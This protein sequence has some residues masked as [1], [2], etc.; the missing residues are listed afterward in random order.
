[1]IQ[2]EQ[3]QVLRIIREQNGMMELAVLVGHK[4]ERAILYTELSAPAVPGETVL[5][6]TTAVRLGLGSGGYHF[7]LPDQRTRTG[8]RDGGHIMKL[9]YTP[10]QVR[11]LSCEETAHPAH[12]AL[13]DKDSLAGMPVIAAELHSMLPAIAATIA[14]VA[15]GSRPLRV[16]YVMTDGA[17]LPIAFSRTVAELKEKGLLC[18]TL[19]VGHSFGGDLEAVNLYSG[20]L[21]AKYVLQAD[22][23]IAAM[24]PG[25]VGTGTRFGHTG[26]EQGQVINAAAS[27]QGTPIA[28]PRISFAD[29]RPRHRGVSHHTLTALGKVALAPALVAVPL[30]DPSSLKTILEQLREYEIPEKHRV[31][32]QDGSVIRQAAACYDL[33]LTT[34]GRTLSEDLPFFMAAA[35]AGRLAVELATGTC[36]QPLAA[37]DAVTAVSISNRSISACGP[38]DDRACPD[39]TA[40]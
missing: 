13:R 11:V 39:R 22:L 36:T 5:L 33:K 2:V 4:E 3:G 17:A 25:I 10:G 1:M 31:C 34:M 21:A 9:R 35:A 8:R 26:V 18:G 28:C 30:L 29:E 12:E 19:T 24:G 40:T 38:L 14:Y 27:L 20:L 32:L 23:A 16:A 37:A 6:N 15:S 7:V